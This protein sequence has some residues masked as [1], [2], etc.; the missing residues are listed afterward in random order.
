MVL[1][2]GLATF[3]FSSVAFGSDLD[4]HCN[5]RG[6]VQRFSAWWNPVEFWSAQP[7]TIQQEVESRI[8][9][10]QVHL[11]QRQAN[12]AIATT[13][14]E[15]TRIE[16]AALEE[17]LRILGVKPKQISPE[18]SQQLDQVLAKADETIEATHVRLDE[19]HGQGV[20]DAI[21][22]GEKCVAIS[23][24]QLAKARR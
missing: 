9:A 12:V 8:K 15:K 24:E 4:Q 7:S 21:R 14:R 17:Q 13:E 22:W 6:W 10:Y 18:M 19:A 11:V 5:P 2:I 23:R 20:A 3:S 1:L 16:Q